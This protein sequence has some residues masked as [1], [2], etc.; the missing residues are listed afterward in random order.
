MNED[1]PAP[2]LK[3]NVTPGVTSI[4][5]IDE[6]FDAIASKLLEISKMW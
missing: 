5:N 2:A 3:N 1:N 4:S 6:E